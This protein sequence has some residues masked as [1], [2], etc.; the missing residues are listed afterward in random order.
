M[1]N[2]TLQSI[3][4]DVVN[5][6]VTFYMRAFNPDES[7]PCQRVRRESITVNFPVITNYVINRIQS[8]CFYD[9]FKYGSLNTESLNT[10]TELYKKING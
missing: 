7:A 2:K 9:V 10:L 1:V 3:N 4:I 5:K 6:Q 8:D